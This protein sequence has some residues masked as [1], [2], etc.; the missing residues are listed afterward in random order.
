[1]D[2]MSDEIW[3]MFFA[4]YEPSCSGVEHSGPLWS[5]IIIKGPNVV[6]IKVRFIKKAG[7]LTSTSSCFIKYFVQKS[8]KQ[9]TLCKY[10]EGN[11]VWDS[12]LYLG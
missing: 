7:G 5:Y 10:F 9:S 8:E 11:Y 3:E 6:L 4:C 1:M 2:Q 12:V